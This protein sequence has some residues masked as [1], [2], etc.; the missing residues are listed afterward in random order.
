MQ[1]RWF[2]MQLTFSEMS[3]DAL[4]SMFREIFSDFLLSFFCEINHGFIACIAMPPLLPR[5]HVIPIL[6][7]WF[8]DV[9]MWFVHVVPL[10]DKITFF[11][12]L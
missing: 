7:T 10:G 8:W 6:M 1:A 11:Y 2:F 12:M 3:A 4:I 9:D 5:M